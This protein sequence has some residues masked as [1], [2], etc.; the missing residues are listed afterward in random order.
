MC[1]GLLLASEDDKPQ[2]RFGEDTVSEEEEDSGGED[3]LDVPIRRGPRTS[4]SA[5]AYGAYAAAQSQAYVPPVIEKTGVQRQRLVA[6]MEKSFVFK[7]LDGDSKETVI[8]AMTEKNF[9]PNQTLIQQGDMVGPEDDGLFMLESG[10]ADVYKQKPG[11]PMPGDKVFTYKEEGAS[12]GE[13]ALLYN[14]PRAATVKTVTACKAWVLSRN[15]FN[16][17]VKGAMQ[18]KRQQYEQFLSSVPLLKHLPAAD[19]SKLTDVLSEQDMKSGQTIVE[20]GKAG[21][22]FFII[23]SGECEAATKAKGVVMSYK[24]QDFFGEL[25]LK[26]SS[27]GLRKA[28]VKCTKDGRLVTVDRGSFRRLLGPLDQQLQKRESEYIK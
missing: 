24:A 3:L 25:A 20:E 15:A 22:T 1:S 8:L 17:L 27:D 19:L 14:A 6:A 21:D 10:Q 18:K 12:F 4:V 9:P 5:E 7:A 28:T 16:H 26:S 2:P 11:G 23:L 13:L